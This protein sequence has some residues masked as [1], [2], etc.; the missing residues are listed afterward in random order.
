MQRTAPPG[1][2]TRQPG[3]D[4]LWF[5]IALAMHVPVVVWSDAADGWRRPEQWPEF[6]ALCVRCV[7]EASVH[8]PGPEQVSGAGSAD[9]SH[10]ANDGGVGAASSCG[11][12]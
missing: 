12:T 8:V 3:S 4:G 5:V 7:A 9:I 1:F 6:E 11:G 10:W 2:Y